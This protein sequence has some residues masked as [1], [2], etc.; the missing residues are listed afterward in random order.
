[1]IAKL[2]FRN[3]K[4]SM[5]DYAIYFVTL[6][7]GVSVFYVFNSITDQTVMVNI[8]KRQD[9]IL[10][11]MK[12][13]LSVASV[14]VSVVLAFLIMYASNFLMRRRKKEFGIYMLLGMGKM[15]IAGILILET[16]IIGVISLVA[17]LGIGTILSQ[18]MS[19]LV[20]NMFEA[21]MS[22][23]TFQVSTVAMGK[24]VVYFV[25]MFAMVIVLD[26]FVV[27]K[28]KLITLLTAQKKAEKNV[29]R[30]P[31]LCLIVFILAVVVL[32]HAYYMV[33]AGV[34]QLTTEEALIKQI[35]KGIVSTV[36]IFWSLSGLLIFLAKLSKKSYFRGVNAF[37]TKEISSR[38]NT[39]VFA[40]SVI[41][42]LLFITICIFSTCFSINKSMNDNLK[43]LVPVDVNFM[44]GNQTDNPDDL[45]R[46]KSIG[47][48]MKESG[49]DTTMFQDVVELECWIYEEYVEEED[50]YYSNGK[51]GN[52]TFANCGEIVKLSDWN[53]VAKLYG[54]EQQEL[55]EDEYLIVANYQYTVESYNKNYLQKNHIIRLGGKEYHPRYKECQ[56][57]YLIMDSN[58]TNL[59]FTVVP[60]SVP[61]D[62][63]MRPYMQYYLANYNSNHAKSVE[64][65]E[66][67]VYD[68][69]IQQEIEKYNT[70][71]FIT[72]TTKKEVY[73]NS[74]GLT[75]LIVFMGLYLGIIFLIASAALLS[76]KELSQAAD[77]REKYRVL[78][79]I[80]V[81]EKMIRG[82]LLKQNMIFFGAPLLLAGIHSIFGI[83]VCIYIIET[84][85]K[86]GLR[87]GIVFTA[88]ILVAIYSIY[89]VITYRCS[90]KIISEK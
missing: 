79:E 66:N 39:N 23:F 83:K 87:Q 6:I 73:E 3:M 47:D 85:G 40:G 41:C 64:E 2:A 27:G 32:G 46:G 71:V 14:I 17:G 57:G 34:Q 55:E 49:I 31:W 61:E 21:D 9:D 89:F 12:G 52:N 58:Y 38:V 43:T 48:I 8:L 69:R 29:A 74:I 37:T 80:G 51:D 60:D 4:K 65:I 18:G 5:S 24:T 75:A 19:I 50:T 67:Y 1:M 28:S 78:R 16:V 53:K 90:R 20:A 30:N 70:D 62:P 77:N 82:S 86:S 76:L 11:L 59:G 36:F 25:I 7:I 35:V 22:K 13:M 84:F 68:G 88:C 15:K 10:E 63:N 81:D 26:L 33:T 54:L 45:E 72:P 44:N 56:N 42:L